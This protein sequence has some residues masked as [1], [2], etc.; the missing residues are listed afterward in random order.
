MFAGMDWICVGYSVLSRR[1]GWSNLQ[2]SARLQSGPD[3]SSL[4]RDS[5]SDLL[6]SSMLEANRVCRIGSFLGF[7]TN[8]YQEK[9]YQCVLPLCSARIIR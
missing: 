2:N 7:L 3:R 5:V 6:V 8:F 1:V 4:S 9:L